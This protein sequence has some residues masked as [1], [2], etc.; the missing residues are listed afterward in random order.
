MNFKNLDLLTL[1]ISLFILN[2]CK[3]PS[4]IGLDINDDLAVQSNVY[5]DSTLT[6]KLIKDD[7]IITN[8]QTFSP[9]GYFKDPL[10]GTT[11]A[12]LSFAL[13]LPSSAINFDKSAQLDSAILVLP[14][15]GFYGDSLNTNYTV[16]VNEL[17]ELSYDP[18]SM[19]II[20]NTKAFS[21]KPP[22][23]GEKNFKPNI[24]DSIIIQDI[25]VG[26]KDLEKKVPAQL[27]IKLDETF[28][29]NVILKADIAKFKNNTIFTNYLKG[30][31]VRLNKAT[32]TNNGGI[33]LFN[34]STP[35]AAR[36]DIFFKE[37]KSEGKIDTLQKSFL[38]QGNQGFASSQIEWNYSGTPVETAFSIENSEKNYLKSLA[39][40]KIK[41]SFP[42]LNK[43]KNLGKNILVNK[44]ELIIPVDELSQ[45]PY[46]PLQ[47]IS[48]YKLD[49]ANRPQYVPDENQSDPRYI[50]AG[51][52]GGFYNATQ[53]LYTFNLT[54]YVQ[55]LLDKKIP[56]Y[57]TYLSAMNSFD[58]KNTTSRIK[59]T[60]VGGGVGKHKMKL[61]IFYTIH[62]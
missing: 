32:T 29:N 16:N 28:I 19:P 12:V 39:G 7:V 31:Q 47:Q 13:T 24:K 14:F 46:H 55:D 23:L 36:L 11:E 60:V 4:T 22:L 44:A 17:V 53:K 15:A 51:Y 8:Y 57:G 18:N 6:T 48:I 3:D 2:G 5:I 42:N 45:A 49:I 38:I 58:G 59:R 50:G 27:R 34:T 52:V 62:N 40:T 10:F 1:L 43:I 35:N 30:L 56:N 54:G 9:M 41:I 33:F 26:K 20:Y 21:T 37:T 25:I 61:K